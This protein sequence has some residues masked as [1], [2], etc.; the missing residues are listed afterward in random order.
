MF[1][2]TLKSAK[3]RRQYLHLQ[4]LK[5]KKNPKNIAVG[6]AIGHK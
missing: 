1:R 5:K 4:D 2:I 6:E 3:I